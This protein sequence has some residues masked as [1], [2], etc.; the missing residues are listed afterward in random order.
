[1]K[2]TVLVENTPK[3]A[4]IK[5]EH[6]LSFHIEACGKKILLDAGQGSLFLENAAL[7]GRD[8]AA[9][10]FAVLSHGHGDHSGG[11]AAFREVN[12]NAPIYM[13]RS[14]TH[15][16]YMRKFGIIYF[17]V[18]MDRT[19]TDDPGIVPLDGDRE[20]APGIHALVGFSRKADYLTTS[21][22]LYMRKGWGFK[23]DDF[24]HEL[25]LV[26]R[27]GDRTC[28]FSSC[29]HTGLHNIMG[30]ISDAGLLAAKNHVFAGMH[31]YRAPGTQTESPAILDRFASDLAAFPNTTYYA[32]HCTGKAAYE[33]LK[34]RL[35]ERIQPMRCGDL[36]EL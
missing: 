3:D 33:R 20:L 15:R 13:A 5:A 23:R 18:G 7:L 8:L 14:A 31:L 2:I 17:N 4:S 36:F 27:E 9:I 24:S 1:M 19:F 34:T 11:L 21:S 26:V 28:V 25:A 16:C 22:N 32:G 12:P 30:K 35:G 29:S 6:G 10:D